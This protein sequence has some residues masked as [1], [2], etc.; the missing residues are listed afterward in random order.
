VKEYWGEQ[1]GD[2]VRE[3]AAGD[4]VLDARSGGYRDLAPIPAGVPNY[5][6]DVVSANGGKALNHFNKVHKGEVV[7]ALVADS[8]DL[9]APEDLVNWAKSA[10]II[11]KLSLDSITLIV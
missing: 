8:P 11:I 1:V 5:Y 9:A 7:S 3:M 2:A 6:L 4:W 10:G